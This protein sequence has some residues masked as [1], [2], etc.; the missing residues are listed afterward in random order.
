MFSG[1]TMDIL[2]HKLTELFLEGA[3]HDPCII[4]FEN[5]DQFFP[6]PSSEAIETPD[7]SYRLGYKIT[8]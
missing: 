4:V 7:S 8:I 2:K 5:I 3:K 1:K 6:P